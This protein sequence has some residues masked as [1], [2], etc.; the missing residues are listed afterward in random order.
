MDCHIP[1]FMGFLRQ[2]YWNE[3]LFPP[4]GNLPNLGI[5]PESLTSPALAGGFF[6]TGVLPGK[7]KAR[8]G[9]KYLSSEYGEVLEY[10]VKGVT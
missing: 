1:L 8:V 5:K 4:P 2:E 6:T 9:H 10:L 3:L 7:P